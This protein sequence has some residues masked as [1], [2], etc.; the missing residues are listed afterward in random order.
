M[1]SEYFVVLLLLDSLLP[2][3]FWNTLGQSF[4]GAGLWLDNDS[5][6]LST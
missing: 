2:S 6:S 5:M 4:T 3:D 1:L